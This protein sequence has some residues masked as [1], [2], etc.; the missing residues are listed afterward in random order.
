MALVS[1]VYEE[2]G[3]EGLASFG[4]EG[5][6]RLSEAQQDKLKALDH[7]DAASG[8]PIWP[9]GSAGRLPGTRQQVPG[10]RS[11]CAG[12]SALHGFLLSVRYL[13]QTIGSGNAAEEGA[14][15]GIDLHQMKA[16]SAAWWAGEDNGKSF[17]TALAGAKSGIAS[18]QPRRS[19]R[20]H[21]ARHRTELAAILAELKQ[22]RRAAWPQHAE[23]PRLNA[24]TAASR[25]NRVTMRPTTRC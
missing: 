18:S 21:A 7:R 19:A 12:R 2:D 24:G 22:Q 13:R 16:R 3:I 5:A 11:R 10:V 4:Y 8:S 14:R 1:A 20:P 17:A 9:P 23:E 6:C 25:H 15:T